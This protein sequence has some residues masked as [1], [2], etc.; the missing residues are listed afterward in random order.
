[1]ASKELGSF[2]FKQI[3][4]NTGLY[5]KQ[6]RI[7]ESSFYLFMAGLERKSCI[8]GRENKLFIVKPARTKFLKNISGFD[9][10]VEYLFY[11]CPSKKERT[12][13]NW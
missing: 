3:I 5:K 10:K 4:H 2:T 9:S 7:E 13:R 1:M 12:W 6:I 11:I 8:P